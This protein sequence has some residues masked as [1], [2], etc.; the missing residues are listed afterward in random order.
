M[1]MFDSLRNQIDELKK[2]ETGFGDPAEI[3]NS[4]KRLRRSLQILENCVPSWQRLVEFY[5]TRSIE[6]FYS[7]NT[8]NCNRQL[9][10]CDQLRPIKEA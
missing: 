8:V 10:N 2:I 1:F 4:R 3:E 6:L 7:E 5:R 9:R